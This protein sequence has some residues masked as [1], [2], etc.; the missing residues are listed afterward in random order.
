MKSGPIIVIDN[1]VDDQEVFEDVLKSLGVSNELVLLD[2]CNDALNYL[3]TTADQPFVIFC[4]V[5]MPGLSGIEFKRRIDDDQ[6]LRRKS[7]PF[8]FYSTSVDQKTV[9]EA[10]TQMTVQG[11]FQKK[12]SIEEIKDAIRLI[13]DYWSECKH[14]NTK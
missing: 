3:K 13:L 2:N 9:N 14:P 12:N 1:D 4:D 6:Q 8:V 11:F 10:Y 5:N 7:I